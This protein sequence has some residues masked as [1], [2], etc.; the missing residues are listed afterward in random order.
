MKQKAF[1]LIEIVV[2]LAIIVVL[3]SLAIPAIR[4]AIGSAQKAQVLSNV[5]Q[6]YS[7]VM[8]SS[9]D[10]E[11]LWPSTNDFS[12]WVKALP[13]RISTNDV[14]A[15]FSGGGITVSN[16]PPE[17]SAILVYSVRDFSNEDFIFAS[18]HNWNATTPSNLDPESAPFGDSGFVYVTKG[19]RGGVGKSKDSTNVIANQPAPLNG[20]PTP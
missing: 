5:K 3:A 12:T 1:S 4:G 16:F 18:S 7:S 17:R 10:G 8:A 19:G 14:K 15:L 20:I 9:T 2:V 11:N 13:P 6:L